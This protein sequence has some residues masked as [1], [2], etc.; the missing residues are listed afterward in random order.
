MRADT[1]KSFYVAQLHKKE[2]NKI[3]KV[4]AETILT[5]YG[6]APCAN[7]A[8]LIADE[9]VDF[10]LYSILMLSNLGID[11]QT[12]ADERARRFSLSGINKKASRKK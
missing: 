4:V 5:T 10:R 6:A 7:N 11:A 1:I 2:L 9:T 8:G 12:V 3:F